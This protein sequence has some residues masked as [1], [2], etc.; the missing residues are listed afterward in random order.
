MSKHVNNEA[1]DT[2]PGVSE[3][4]WKEAVVYQIYPRSFK[5]SNGDGIGDLKGILSKLDYVKSLHVDVIWLNPIFLSPN[6]DNGYD[7]SDYYEIMKECGTMHTFE[8]LLEETHKRGMKLVLDLVVNHTSDEHPW[9][10]EARKSRQNPYHNYYLWWPA[11]AG[12]PPFRPSY[13]DE[14]GTAWMYNKP[15][16]SYYLHYFSKKQPDLNWE[17]PD[18]RREVFDMM[19]FWFEKGIDGFRMDSISL[20]A[21]DPTF[22]KLN[23]EQYPGLFEFY[24]NGPHLHTY[25][26]EMNREVLS[27]Y[28]CMTVGE[29]SA[30]TVDQVAKFVEPERHEL[31]MLY[32]F[33][34]A[35]VRNTSKPDSPDSGIDYSLIEL[36]KMFTKW[37]KAVGNGWPAIYLGNHDQPRMVSR[38]GNDSPKYRVVS[39]KMLATFLLTMRGTPYWYAGDEIGMCNIKFDNIDDY[40][41]IDTR[42]RYKKAE[43]NGEDIKAFL[44]EQKQ[45]GRDNA[46]TPFQWNDTKNAGFTTGTPW[47]KVNPDY[48]TVNVETEEKK[49]SSVLNYFK[50]VIDFRRENKN[51]IYGNYTLL[52]ADNIQVFTYLRE[53]EEDHFLVVLNFTPKKATT[54]PGIDI[55]TA[56]IVLNNYEEKAKIGQGD[57]ITLR[58]FEA[59]VLKL[60]HPEYESYL[61]SLD[62][63]G[64]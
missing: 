62:L 64:E 31:D 10:E 56:E 37:D 28:D 48:P 46:R 29:G 61:D 3:A 19:K 47:L 5:D 52:D 2:K 12:D 36:K 22:P 20:I 42:N 30:V 44:E 11:E 53:K 27:H 17:N 38:F 35:W 18:V 51:L 13:F 6:A 63:L 34:A 54:T 21:K 14:E 55:R 23:P 4:W 49:K 33:D 16:D 45:I 50:K 25:L 9:F 32:H 7:I 40:N 8:L 15:T 43:L 1:T 26:H 57:Q 24:A 58:P 41:D 60:K 59:I 39:A